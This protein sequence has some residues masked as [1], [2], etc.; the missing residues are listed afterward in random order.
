[1]TGKAKIL[2]VED[3]TIVSL[4]LRNS[5]KKLGYSVSHSVTSGEQA[6]EFIAKKVPDLILMD[7]MLDGKLD[8][9]ST[10]HLIRKHYKIPIIYLTANTDD[11]SFEMAKAT[12]PFAFIEKPFK[13]KILKR[14]FELLIEQISNESE[15]DTDAFI[16]K[17]RVFVRENNNTMV[18]INLEDILY[19]EADRA[20]CQIATSEK[21]YLITSSLGNLE[22]KLSSPFLMR[23]H[24]SYLVN[25]Q[26]IDRIEEN[27]ITIGS[28]N[29]T[30][31]RS[32]WKDFLNRVKII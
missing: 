1:M 15:S 2:I 8:G 16:L 28:K 24:R 4:H 17:D 19:I 25:L 31:S 26:Q 32:Y 5:L 14:T 30:V 13:K 10:V 22:Q 3:E 23:V 11:Q 29:I 9:I 18:K 20:Y 12:K 27:S 7:I 21:T 6:L